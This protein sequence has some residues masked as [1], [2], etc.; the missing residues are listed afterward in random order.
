M[1]DC[2]EIYVAGWGGQTNSSNSVAAYSTTDGFP[3]TSD[4]YQST[5]SGSNFYLAVYSANMTSLTYATFMGSTNGSSDHVDGGTSRFDKSGK[6]YH[7]VCAACGGNSNGFPTTSGAYSETNN[8]GNCNL[9]AFL[10]ELSQIEATLST[11]TPVTCI[12]DPT[13]FENDS[14]N[15]NAYEW[16]FGDGNTSNEFEPSHEYTT[17]GD[18]NVMLVVSDINGCYE[19]DTAYVD[20]TIINPVYEVWSAVDSV[21]PGETV[22]VFA[23]GGT[24]YSWSPANLFD[25]PTSSSPIATIAGETELTVDITSDCGSSTETITIYVFGTDATSAGDTAI[26]VGSQ[27][28]LSAGGGDFY[29]WSPVE[30]LDDPS[31]STPIATPLITTYYTVEIITPEGCFIYDTTRVMVDQDLPFPN[32]VDE[33]TICYG[34]SIQ[35]AAHGATSYQWSPDYNISNTQI[36]N[37]YVSPYVDTSYAVSFTNACGTTYDTVDVNV[38]QI[39]GNVSTDTI[40]CP[41][42]EAKLWANGGNTYQWSPS[43][44]L[45]HSNTDTT[46]AKP[47]TPTEYLVTITDNYG[48]QTTLSTFVDLYE[49]PDIQVS[50]DVYAIQGDSTLLWAQAEGTILWSPDYYLSC[51]S[52]SETMATPQ[53]AVTYTATVT[54]QNGCQ[55]SDDVNVYFDPLIYVPNAFTPNADAYNNTFYVTA[56]NIS[57]FTMYI[58]NRWGELIYVS[59]SIDEGWNGNYNGHE[60]LDDVYVWKIIYTDLNGI[61]GELMGHVTLLR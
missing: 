27:A 53:Q 2:Y 33:V 61:N 10:F 55:N 59:N 5:T 23:S 52:C 35:I 44:T 8:S 4:A 13:L 12:P 9:A 31:S 50:T 20:V 28:Q 57:E 34:E 15:G 42:G 47:H 36:Y 41:E 43:A 46:I 45:S 26:C 7:A 32:L 21:C 11:T 17:P 40:I 48:C 30:T 25:D 1:S 19:P 14:E 22:Q 29:N 37:P 49:T 39:T 6:V 56:N 3:V 60:A 54:D 18:Y 16:D 38:I 58:F 24:S 51:T